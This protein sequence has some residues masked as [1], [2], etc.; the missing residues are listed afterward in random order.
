LYIAAEVAAGRI[1]P[2]LAPMFERNLRDEQAGKC[3]IIRDPKIVR[4]FSKP[5]WPFSGRL[6]PARRR[7]GFGSGNALSRGNRTAA[8]HLLDISVRTLRNKI[9][10]YSA[11]GVLRSSP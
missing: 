2:A 8:A 5:R 11:E 1:A 10:E 4:K 6:V 9:V 3:V 7:T